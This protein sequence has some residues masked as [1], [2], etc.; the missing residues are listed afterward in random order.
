[1]QKTA[2]ETLPN[3][4]PR[5]TAAHDTSRTPGRAILRR[6]HEETKTNGVFCS[7]GRPAPHAHAR[8]EQFLR[9][10]GRGRRPAARRALR[11]AGPQ[12]PERPHH[13]ALVDAVVKERCETVQNLVDLVVL[14]MQTRDCRGGKGERDLFQRLFWELLAF[15]PD[16]ALKLIPLLPE[17][18][19]YRDLPA[20]W[21][22]VSN[23]DAEKHLHQKR[24]GR[25]G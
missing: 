20:L 19:S 15:W 12:L 5:A 7:H 8:R 6:R 24:A 23:P 3:H 9:A 13:G 11:R 1:M 22:A 25:G 4:E 16:V 21:H 14:T 18:G 10:I 2:S 17:Y